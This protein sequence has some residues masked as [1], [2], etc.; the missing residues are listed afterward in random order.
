MSRKDIHVTFSKHFKYLLSTVFNYNKNKKI[1]FFLIR[2]L[3]EIKILCFSQLL[4]K[5]LE[6]LYTLTTQSIN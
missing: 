5:V 2:V 4:R 1:N 6:I 3:H